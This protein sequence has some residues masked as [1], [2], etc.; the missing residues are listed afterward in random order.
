MK[1]IARPYAL[2]ELARFHPVSSDNETLISTMFKEEYRPQIQI[3]TLT[4]A[5]SRR[6]LLF[7]L[8]KCQP[9]AKCPNTSRSL[10]VDFDRTRYRPDL[11][12][13][14][15]TDRIDFS[16]AFLGVSS[17]RWLNLRR[18]ASPGTDEVFHRVP[19]PKLN[20]SSRSL[21]QPSLA[22]FIVKKLLRPLPANQVLPVADDYLDVLQDLLGW[23][24]KNQ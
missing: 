18:F 11:V 10:S 21:H 13:L 19:L 1:S 4:N 2:R 23:L 9:R 24:D 7:G 15:P 5:K 8:L 14:I 12:D 22:E 3:W 20:L 17:Q 6:K 16:H